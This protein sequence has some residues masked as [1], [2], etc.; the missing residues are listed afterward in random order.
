M[1]HRYFGRRIGVRSMLRAD[2]GD[3][4]LLQWFTEQLYKF[5]YENYYNVDKGIWKI[6]FI[7]ETIVDDEIITEKKHYK[8]L[9]GGKNDNNNQEDPIKMYDRLL[10]NCDKAI[11]N[12]LTNGL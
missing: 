9:T 6:D 7:N 1:K 3:I 4:Q 8:S 5:L 2:D 11:D 10:K 12:S